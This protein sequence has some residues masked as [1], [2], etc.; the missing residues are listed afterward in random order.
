MQVQGKFQGIKMCLLV[1]M[2]LKEYEFLIMKVFPLQYK[3]LRTQD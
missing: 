2:K 1:Q 3:Q